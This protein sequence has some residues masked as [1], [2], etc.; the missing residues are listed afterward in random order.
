MSV[1]SQH[2]NLKSTPQ[3]QQVPG[4]DQ[5]QNN[6]GGFVFQVDIWTQLDRFLILG[7]EGGSYY[8]TEKEMTL[9]NAK[10]VQKCLDTDGRRTVDHIVEI[11]DKGRAPKNDPAVFALA[12]ASSCPNLETR[13][14]ALK[15][16]SMV[17]RIPT[18]L[19]QFIDAVTKMRG[20]GRSLRQAVANW[21]LES[22]PR[23]LAY[24]LVKYQN[25]E[26]WNHRDAL[27]LSHP[28]SLDDGRNALLRY[29]A[30]KLSEDQLMLQNFSSYEKDVRTL[31]GFESLK[32][33]TDKK[34]VVELI[35][36][37]NL[38]RECVPTE[39]LKEA[40]VWEA[41]LEDMPLT[42]MI[43]NLAT[44]TR[45]GLIA[46]MSNAIGKVR[47]SLNEERIHSSRVHPITLLAALKTYAL[48][49]SEHT[50][51]HGRVIRVVEWNP[52]PQVVDI[53]DDSFYKAFKNVEPTG[54]RFYLGCDVSGSMGCGYVGGVKGLTPREATGALAMVTIIA[55]SNYY[56]RG[57]SHELVDLPLSPKMRLDDVCRAMKGIPFGVTD[58]ALPMLDAM[59]RKIP[60]DVFMVLT[61]NETWAG[62]IHPYQALKQY[63]DKMGIPA[64]LV[65]VGMTA[66]E[67][68]IADPNDVGMLD[69]VG[70]DTA[71]PQLIADFATN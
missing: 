33:A 18:H 25:R 59:E 69:V 55:E 14:Y 22:D 30:G 44:M 34:N 16:L 42:A 7:N 65:V 52:V 35:R 58:C 20:W 36:H 60:V 5:V 56:V 50:D 68:S 48:G 1:Y 61:D 23:T 71:V 29:A 10:C 26:G 62:E 37:Y 24:H 21:Y 3:R 32:R 4:K 63:R 6:A 39:W 15:H 38:P 40:S 45:V 70:F 17:C 9:N 12:M 46:P 19:F 13:Q 53:L 54:K 41:L 67:F 57:F 66:T 27:R 49:R 31:V 43:R 64:K 51:K 28:K 8:C 47:E 2:F 11:S